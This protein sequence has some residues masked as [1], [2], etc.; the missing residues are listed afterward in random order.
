[1]LSLPYTNRIFDPYSTLAEFHI[2]H[3][4][5]LCTIQCMYVQ[6]RHLFMMGNMRIPTYLEY[7]RV[8]YSTVA[9]CNVSNY[10]RQY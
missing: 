7:F 4:G 8:L 9:D 6:H 5:M 3:R 10:N 1:M 2:V